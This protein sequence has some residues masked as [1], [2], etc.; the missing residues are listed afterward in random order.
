MNVIVDAV[1]FL[2]ISLL[3]KLMRKNLSLLVEDFVLCYGIE[4]RLLIWFAS[5]V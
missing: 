5:L 1:C 4:M 2:D 3:V